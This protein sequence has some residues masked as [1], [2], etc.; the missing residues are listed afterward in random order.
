[1]T[2]IKS[3]NVTWIDI[4]QPSPKELRFL[5][6]NY[7]VHPLIIDG[8]E[9]PTIRS[10]AED[11]NGYIYLVLHFPVFNEQK[12]VSEP[13]EIDF[14]I[15][16]D[17]I[18]S[19]RYAKIDPLD[20]FLEKCKSAIEH[21]KKEAMS[22]GA[23]YLFYYLIKEMYAFS[24]RQLDHMDENI[25][26]IEEGIF[27]GHHKEMLLALSL[28]RSDV[29]NFLRTLRPQGAVLESLLAR[30]DA[31]EQKTRPYLIDLLGEHHQVL[32]Q[33]ENNRESIEGLQTTNSALLEHK[34]GE[35]MKVLTIMAFVTFPLTLLA[36][37]F[38]M[39]TITMPIIG[40]PNDFWIIIGIMLS[41]VILFFAFF[42]SKKWL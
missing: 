39:N 4:K 36:N 40:K 8:L 25:E 26:K 6:E 22:R 28:A 10:Q 13:V 21:T 2:T 5:A 14:I 23:I 29:L 35:I 17:T 19:V 30:S 16:P 38:S 7:N 27:S 11:Y 9:K 32:N 42:K 3:P 20:E 34:T 31:F 41:A 1:M 33:A 24:L 15:T 18:I 37:I 12:K